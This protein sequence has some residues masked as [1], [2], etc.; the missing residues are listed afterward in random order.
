MAS[1]IVANTQR[2]GGRA[3]PGPRPHGLVVKVT[4]NTRTHRHGTNDWNRADCYRGLNRQRRVRRMRRIVV[5]SAEAARQ[6]IESGGGRHY[7]AFVTLTYRPDVLWSPR[8]VSEFI[9]RTRQWCARRGVVVRYQW[10]L[11][12]TQRG[13][14]HY[15]VLLWLPKRVQLPKPDKAG[16]WVAGLS[17]IERARSPVGYLVKYASKG[18]DDSAAG[19]IPKG[20]RLF[21]CSNAGD[22]NHQ[23]RRARLPVWLERC[24]EET[25]LPRRI[26][27]VGF[28]CSQTGEIFRSPYKFD[29]CRAS[30]GRYVICFLEEVRC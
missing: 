21:G 4:S 3:Q 8:H 5:R 28:V 20:A 9:R 24:T 15:H 2:T 22:E 6:G 30:D 19:E 27:F 17:R 26:A 13:A 18:L 23:V 14:P 29:V 11:E 10:V 7:A 12:L 1:S 16:W 25:Q